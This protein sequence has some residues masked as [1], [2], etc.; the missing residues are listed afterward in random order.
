MQCYNTFASLRFHS[1]H[2]KGKCKPTSK[3]L[4]QRRKK[5]EQWHHPLQLHCTVHKNGDIRKW[6]GKRKDQNPSFIILFRG[7]P[8]SFE[9]PLSLS[10]NSQ[11]RKKQTLIAAKSL[12]FESTS[13]SLSS[14]SF[15]NSCCRLNSNTLANALLSI[16][17]HL[18][19]VKRI[20]SPKLLY[21]LIKMNIVW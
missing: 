6:E 20:I 2:T 17:R 21:A 11:S 8:S 5:N 9:T 18:P 10:L 19:M 13:P 16:S 3:F 14:R 12:E 15:S 4:S 7:L 1:V